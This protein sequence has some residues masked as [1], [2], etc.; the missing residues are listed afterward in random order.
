MAHFWNVNGQA[1]RHSP[2]QTDGKTDPAWQRFYFKPGVPLT[3]RDRVLEAD[4]FLILPGDREISGEHL[5]L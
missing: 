5:I 4:L 1:R 3:E 2:I